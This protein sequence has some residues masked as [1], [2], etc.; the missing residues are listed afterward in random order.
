MS[1]AETLKAL[2]AEEK[3][4]ALFDERFQESLK[5]WEEIQA[6]RAVLRD[7]FSDSDG[8]ALARIADLVRNYG[9]KAAKYLGYPGLAA[10]ATAFFADDGA[11]A[12]LIA[13]IPLPLG[14]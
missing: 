1:F 14:W 12:G 4:T 3:A 10:A 9:P 6:R 2:D 8:D 11:F 7:R 13:K 5:E